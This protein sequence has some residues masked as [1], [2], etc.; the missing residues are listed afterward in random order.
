M[1]NL[2]FIAAS[3][4]ACSG[5]IDMGGDDDDPVVTDVQMFVRDGNVPVAGVRVI[6]Q[7]ADDTVIL[8]SITDGAGVALAEMPDGGNITVIRTYPPAI[9][10]EDTRP[11]TLFT[12]VGVKGGDRLELGEALNETAPASAINIA[13]P[14]TAQGNISVKT[15]CGTGTG[16]GDGTGPTLIPLTVRGCGAN[17]TVYVTDGDN[18]SFAMNAPY[19][20][21]V[22]VSSGAFLGSL[23]A[24]I[25]AINVLPDTSVVVEKRLEMDNF[26]FFSTGEKRVETTPADVDM[27]TLTAVNQVLYTR[28]SSNI[29]GRSQIVAERK[30]YETGSTI[31][32]ASMPLIPFVR[33]PTYAPTGISWVEQ[34][35]AQAQA[36][37]VFT[38]FTV[39][40]DTGG[41]PPMAGDVYVRA[42]IA[43]HS[44]GALLTMPRL[45]GPADSMYNPGAT[46]Q[47]A[48]SLGILRITG[49]GYDA[50]RAK[51]FTSASILD[52]A[53]MDNLINLSYAG[54]NPPGF[55]N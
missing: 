2:L 14:N 8:D 44:D 19:G 4:T 20:E 52:A 23:G 3:L 41:A 12:Y 54:N 16:T 24:Q 49:G 6:F 30:L 34:G 33:T 32:D 31:V 35:P 21:N 28:I 42:I 51:A 1:R 38:T 55:E 25:S 26:T 5:S 37:A 43:P 46:D 10:I 40:R 50:L 15:Q 27:P 11:T 7:A 18:S 17:L 48:G 36:D 22:D 47:I 29:D 53:P 39:T 13:V 9:P 45:Q